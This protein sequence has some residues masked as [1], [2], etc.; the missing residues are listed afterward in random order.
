MP[1]EIEKNIKAK[2]RRAN[3]N[4]F[5]FLSMENDDERILYFMDNIIENIQE[6]GNDR[7]AVIKIKTLNANE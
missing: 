5:R 6:Y 1:L 2:N 4:G 3:N 7:M